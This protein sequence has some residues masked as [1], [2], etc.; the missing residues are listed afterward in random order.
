MSAYFKLIDTASLDK[1]LA[2]GE[3]PFSEKVFS[4]KSLTLLNSTFNQNQIIETILTIGA[5][6]DF[7]VLLK[8]YTKAEITAVIKSSVI[9]DKKPQTFVIY[10]LIFLKRIY[11]LLQI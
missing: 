4:Q 2:M 9:L 6:E 3:Y 5:L 10:I 11:M 7:Y 1:K 8:L